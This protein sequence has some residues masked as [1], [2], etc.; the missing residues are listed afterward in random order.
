MGRIGIEARTQAFGL[1]LK[2]WIG[3]PLLLLPSRIASGSRL[4][5]ADIGVAAEG[6]PFFFAVEEVLP[7]ATPAA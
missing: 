3:P 6:Q 2:D 4:L 5:Q 7:E 1:S